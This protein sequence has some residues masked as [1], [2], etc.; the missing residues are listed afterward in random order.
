MGTMSG[1]AASFGSGVSKWGSYSY[2][3][4]GQ[5][6]PTAKVTADGTGLEIVAGFVAPVPASSNYMGLGLF[7]SST[8]CLDVSAYTGIQ[9]DFSGDLGGWNLQAG[10]NF[11]GDN[12]SSNDMAR[13]ACAGGNS[14]CYNPSAEVTAAALAATP[15]APTIRV[16]F[17]SFSGGMPFSALDPSTLVTVQ[18]QLTQPA[19]GSD[20]GGCAADFTVAKVAFYK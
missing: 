5:T 11:S 15:A 4:P 16:P 17:A 8:S 6:P 10:I 19:G 14:A 9:F 7:F 13:G 3:A 1:N 2:A 12:A 18:W 20:G